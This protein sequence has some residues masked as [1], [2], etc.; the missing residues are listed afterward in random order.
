M[1]F[2]RAKPCHGLLRDARRTGL[3]EQS[4]VGWCVD[5]SH[6]VCCIRVYKLHPTLLCVSICTAPQIRELLDAEGGPN[7]KIVVQID[8]PAAIRNYDDLLRVSD[9]IMVSRTNLGMVIKPEKVGCTY[10]GSL[11]GCIVWVACCCA[12]ETWFLAGGWCPTGA[13]P[14]GTA[15]RP[16]NLCVRPVWHCHDAPST[17]CCKI[18]QAL[19]HRH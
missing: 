4:R 14:G 7:V 16:A 17:N 12:E 6:I 1:S 18:I 13:R 15:G 10:R 19:Q 3:L 9:A 5:N 2:Y 8:T 11:G